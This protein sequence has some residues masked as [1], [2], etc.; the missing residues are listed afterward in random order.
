MPQ[1]CSDTFIQCFPSSN[2]LLLSSQ[3]GHLLQ[4]IGADWTGFDLLASE[5]PKKRNTKQKKSK[6]RTSDEE[7]GQEY[8]FW[9][10]VLKGGP[11]KL[12]DPKF[13]NS[14]L[15]LCYPDDFE[16]SDESLAERCLD[17][18]RGEHVIHI[19]ELMRTGGSMIDSPWSVFIVSFTL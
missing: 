4:Q 13:R 16:E 2:G 7:A 3:W 6:K 1:T 10:T 17:N 14:T 19:G 15:L 12:S 18:F 8:P 9:T 5:P 11:K